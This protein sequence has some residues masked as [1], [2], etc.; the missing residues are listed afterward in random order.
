MQNAHHA[1][2]MARTLADGLAAIPG[3]IVAF[4]CQA[5]EVFAYLPKRLA[6]A[7]RAEDFGFGVWRDE[8]TRELVR[9]VCAFNTPASDVNAILEA[10][11]RLAA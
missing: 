11:N 8:E 7:L 1:N 6:D 4:S 10:A 3:C 2:D 9:F 5:N